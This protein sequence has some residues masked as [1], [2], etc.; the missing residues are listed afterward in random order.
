MDMSQEPAETDQGQLRGEERF[1]M[2]ALAAFYSGTWWPGED[3]PDAYLAC[4]SETIAVEISMLTQHVPG[5]RGGTH[6]RLSDDIPALKMANEL[7]AELRNTIGDERMVLLVLNAPI[8]EPRKTKA[9]LMVRIPQLVAATTLE[10]EEFKEDICGN[11]IIIQVASHI[12]PDRKKVV[13]FIA[14]RRSS[15]DILSN[16][17]YILEERIANKTKLCRHL[18]S[19]GPLWLALLNDYWLADEITYK[20]AMEQTSINHPF[21]RILLIS[22]NQ[23]VCVL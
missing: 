1:V 23:S 9:R 8:L 4:S 18:A 10:T 20:Q 2:S 12:D 6:A 3:P 7:D 14:N 21:D 15:A 22:S 17:Q 13:A 11:C 5:E 19:K 16:A